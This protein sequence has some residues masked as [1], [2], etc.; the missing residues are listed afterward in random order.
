IGALIGNPYLFR[1]LAICPGRL[2]DSIFILGGL[3]ALLGLLRG[4]TWLLVGGLAAATCGRSEAVF[5]L[6]A[7]APIG[8]LLS[9]DWRAKTQRARITSAVLAL[10]VPIAVY[11]ILR[12]ADHT[13]SV[14]DHPKFFGLTI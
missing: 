5:P 4:N 14:R 3:V 11:A 12:L 13:F 2:A 6:A 1:F 7:L 9:R 10:G 8:V